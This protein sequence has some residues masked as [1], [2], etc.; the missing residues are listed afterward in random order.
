MPD[1]TPQPPRFEQALGELDKILRDLE[2]GTTSLEAVLARYE[3]GVGR[4]NSRA[5]APSG[6]RLIDSMPHESAT[7]TTPAFTSPDLRVVAGYPQEA[8]VRLLREGIGLGDREGSEE[9]AVRIELDGG[10][11]DNRFAAARDHRFAEML[12][13]PGRGQPGPL[14][15]G[16]N[17]RE[18]RGRR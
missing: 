10:A 17:G 11:A 18:V 12:E 9:R 1:S 16:C 13:Q 14:Q 7:S 4:P 5:A 2:D 6:T 8:F 3:R 15:Q